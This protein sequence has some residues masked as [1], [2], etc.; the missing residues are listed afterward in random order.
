MDIL[1]ERGKGGKRGGKRKRGGI[2]KGGKR[3]G[4]RKEEEMEK[5]SL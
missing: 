2:G 1:E 3:G 5:S 4:K